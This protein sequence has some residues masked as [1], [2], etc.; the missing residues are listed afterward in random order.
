MTRLLIEGDPLITLQSDQPV[1]TDSALIVDGNVIEAV[2]PSEE[3]RLRGPFEEELGGANSVVLPGLWNSHLHSE[4]AFWPG[5]FDHIFERH[6]IWVHE[7]TGPARE[8]DIYW[9]TLA[10]ALRALKSGTTGILDFFYGRQGMQ[11]FGAEPAVQAFIDSGLRAAIGLGPRDQSR[12]V[13]GDDEEFLATLPA[14]LADRV[15]G[16][17]IGYA[18][19]WDEVAAAFVALAGAYQDAAGGRFRVM[20]NPDWT[21]AA[22][23]ELYR[24]AKALAQEHGATSQT[25][26]LETKYEALY[27]VKNH[28]K[29]GARRLADI[30]FLGP[31]TGVAHFVWATDDDIKAVVDTGATII[32]NP[33]S[34]LR[35]TSGLSPVRDALA[36]GANIAFG[37]DSI[38]VS[39]DD[40]LFE[41]LRLAGLQQRSNAH[42]G[43][44]SGRLSSYTLLHGATHHGA[45]LGG[46]GH[47]IGVLAPG[48][49]ADVV[50]LDRTRIF[51]RGK[52]DHSDPLDVVIDRARGTDVTD[53]V[54]DGRV[55]LRA[56][57]A[58]TVDEDRVRHHVE[59]AAERTFAEPPAWLT[60]LRPTV[61]ELEPHVLAFFKRWDGVEFEP[62]Y[63]VNTTKIPVA[64]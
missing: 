61:A 9:N 58:T 17:I 15:R 16:T 44:E 34:N 64:P 25:H 20:L 6:S 10:I 38:S 41:E 52:F 8:E 54:V 13:H 12:Y 2:G 57:Q 33:G 28:G 4:A 42:G 62:R 43:I 7:A 45:V 19:P 55:V 39:D 26:L 22:S 46:F 56:G 18:Y 51:P 27:N 32:H 36:Q 29:T 11:N 24:A 63:V 3:L 21:A 5:T 37:T 35:L 14:D 60:E 1:L 59:E 48:N 53:S 47:D 50:I 49:R 23:D 40:D 30:G 31:D